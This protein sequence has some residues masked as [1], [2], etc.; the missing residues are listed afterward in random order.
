LI[1]ADARGSCPWWRTLSRTVSA[2]WTRIT[3]EAKTAHIEVE[4]LRRRSSIIKYT[5][6]VLPKRMLWKIQGLDGV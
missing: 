5:V 3:L 6:L 2:P 1:A 4:N